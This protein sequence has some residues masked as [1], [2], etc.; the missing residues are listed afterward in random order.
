MSIKIVILGDGISSQLFMSFLKYHIN[1]DYMCLVIEKK[2]RKD[3][4]YIDDVPF[5]F[6]RVI[7][8]LKEL[9]VPIKVQMGIY[10][11]GEIIDQV[12]DDLVDKYA[13]KTLGHCNNNTIRFIEKEKKAYVVKDENG[14]L[15]RKMM[16]YSELKKRNTK[17]QYLYDSEVVRIDNE[18]QTVY[19][20]NNDKIKYDFLISTIPLIDLNKITGQCHWIDNCLNTYPFYINRF[21]MKGDGRYQVLYCTDDNVR[22]SRIAK[23]NETIFLESREKIDF[24]NI[25]LEEF[26]FISQVFNLNCAP[27]KSYISY[28]GRFQQI[29]DDFYI[30]I[31]KEYGKSNIFLLGRMAT[32]RFKLVEDIYEDCKEICKWIFQKECI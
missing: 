1:M 17:N 24:S 19:T 3:K 27:Q 5:Y 25:T 29:S 15:G 20:V 8:D 12:R 22:F 28:P 9:F 32:W 13:M 4:Q 26:Q 23:L 7:D 16:L 18:T 2:L 30:K 21:L 6:N 31:R 10:D 11:K 14:N